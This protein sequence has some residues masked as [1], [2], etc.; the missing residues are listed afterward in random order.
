MSYTRSNLQLTDNGAFFD[1]VVSNAL[2]KVVSDAAK[3][4]VIQNSVPTASITQ[5]VSGTTYAGADEISYAGTGNDAED[6]V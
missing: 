6:G 1:V 2:G 4:T 5:P 3:L